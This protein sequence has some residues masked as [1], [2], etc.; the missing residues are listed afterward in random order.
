MVR[1]SPHTT[2]ELPRVPDEPAGPLRSPQAVAV[3]ALATIG[4]GLLLHALVYGGWAHSFDTAIYVRSAWGAAHGELW[5]SVRDLHVLSVHF[6]LVLF[7]LAPSVLAFGATFTLLAAQALAFGATIGLAAHGFGA[8]VHRVVPTTLAQQAGAAVL[9]MLLVG[10]GTPLVSNPFLFDLRPDAIG[11]PLLTAGLYRMWRNGDVDGRALAW[12][13]SSLLVREE[14]FMTIVGALVATPFSLRVL[15]QRWRLRL[16]GVVVSIGWWA[17]YWFGVRRWLDDGSFA[18][19]QQVGAEF[20]V[21]TAEAEATL[22]RARGALAL[23][24]LSAGGGLVLLG[25]RWGAAAGPGLLFLFTVDRMPELLLNVHY[26]YFAAPGLVVAAI[27]GFEAAS[28]RALTMR[29]RS[30]LL[31]IPLVAVTG[32]VV[33][34]AW[35]GGGVYRSENFFVAT[36]SEADAE[37]QRV[38]N[39]AALA[40]LYRMLEQVPPDAALAAPHELAGRAAAR[41]L[42]LPVQTYLGELEAPGPRAEIEWVMLQGRWWRSHGRPLVEAYGFRLIDVSGTRGA[43]LTRNPLTPVSERIAQSAPDCPPPV[44]RWPEAGLRLCGVAHAED[45]GVVV[46]LV[47]DSPGKPGPLRLLFVGAPPTPPSEAIAAEAFA[48]LLPPHQLSHG[49]RARFAPSAPL[50]PLHDHLVLITAEGQPVAAVD[51]AGQPMRIVPIP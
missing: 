46:S 22:W 9:A 24:T 3:A 29:A 27:A 42:F 39:R 17:V 21:A 44:V 25:W 18:L 48:G 11:V 31:A 2:A 51:G 23:A 19:A 49:M 32:F 43:L 10:F 35:P 14:Y 38:A 16:F 36:G 26:A 47:R 33:A 6:N 15:R 20:F 45:G 12:L 8:A 13:L 30:G 7:L 34:S 41:R 40:D 4:L 1:A 50:Q 5:N 28:A 37:A